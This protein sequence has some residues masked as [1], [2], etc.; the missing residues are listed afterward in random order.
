MNSMRCKTKNKQ[1]QYAKQRNE[2]QKM[3]EIS[4]KN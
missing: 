3:I 2:N 1:I 4:R